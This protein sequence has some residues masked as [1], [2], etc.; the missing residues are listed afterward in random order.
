M[1]LVQVVVDATGK[2]QRVGREGEREKARGVW[3]GGGGD[4]HT[5]T[6]EHTERESASAIE[7]DGMLSFPPKQ[8]Q[9]GR[10]PT[11]PKRSKKT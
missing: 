11:P 10:L 6:R 1:N 7:S 5:H 4:K 8:T 9:P 2:E 3:G